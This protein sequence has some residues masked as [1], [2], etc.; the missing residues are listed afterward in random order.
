MTPLP[1]IDRSVETSL[2]PVHAV[3]ARFDN[4]HG[5]SPT[6]SGQSSTPPVLPYSISRHLAILGSDVI[7]AND[8]WAENP[9]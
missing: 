9:K 7:S 4:M 3:D 6:T 5:S 1:A 2:Y 8:P